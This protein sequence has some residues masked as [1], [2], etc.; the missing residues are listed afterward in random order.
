MEE[1]TEGKYVIN[2]DIWHSELN[3]ASTMANYMANSAILTKG[4]DFLTITFMLT[5]SQTI[6]GFQI[7][8]DDEWLEPINEK[9]IDDEN[10]RYVLFE[11]N[12]VSQI[13]SGRVQYELGYEGRIVK[14]D[15]EVRLMFA[16]DDLQE[17]E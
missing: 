1:L 10:R 14:G 5:D 6:L 16:T 2:L 17:V 11:L 8:Q 12:E 3:Q 13:M 15:E 7:N 9:V 4:P